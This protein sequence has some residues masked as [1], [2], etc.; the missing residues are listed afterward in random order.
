M[1]KKHRLRLFF[2]RPQ[3]ENVVAECLRP[4]DFGGIAIEAWWWTRDSGGGGSR[5]ETG[6]TVETFAKLVKM[7]RYEGVGKK[8]SRCSKTMC[9][10]INALEKFMKMLVREVKEVTWR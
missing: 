8:D 4:T 10:V 5:S 1:V 7:R 2:Q 6:S 3:C 9:S